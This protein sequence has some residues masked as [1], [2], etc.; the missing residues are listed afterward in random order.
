M[1]QFLVRYIWYQVDSIGVFIILYLIYFIRRSYTSE[2]FH[3]F[4]TNIWVHKYP[5]PLIPGPFQEKGY[6]FVLV[7]NLSKV[8]SQVLPGGGDGCHRQ[9]GGAPPPP[10]RT[11]RYSPD[12]TSC[13]LYTSWEL[14]CSTCTITDSCIWGEH[15]PRRDIKLHGKEVILISLMRSDQASKTFVQFNIDLT[16]LF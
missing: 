13:E 9:D 15:R 11:I 12:W 14:S 8:L 3:K 6:H 5:W 4:C 7:L 2:D 1:C 10:A 16:I